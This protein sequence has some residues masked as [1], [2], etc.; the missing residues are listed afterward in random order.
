MNIKKQT[1]S[2][3]GKGKNKSKVVIGETGKKNSVLYCVTS[4]RDKPKKK[5]NQHTTDRS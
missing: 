1:I 4:Y 3:A 5:K 2:I